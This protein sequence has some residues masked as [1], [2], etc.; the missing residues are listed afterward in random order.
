MKKRIFVFSFIFLIV[1][2][3]LLSGCSTE[4]SV[5]NQK[6][7]ANETTDEQIPEEF[8]GII[9]N[10]LF[11][12]ITAYD[13]RL[14]K[15]EILD[16]NIETRAVTYKV[17]MMDIYGE[18]LAVYTCDTDD[19]YY[20]T[21]LT[22]TEDG[23]FLFVLSFS[24]HYIQSE[25]RWASDKGYTSH[26][27][28]CDSNGNLQFDA[29]FDGIDGSALKYCFEKNGLFYL[30]GDIETSA[31]KQEGVHSPTDI[32]MAI[33]D[34]S[35]KLLDEQSICGSD[36]DSLI[37]AETS[38]DNFLLYV[39]SQSND[40]A[41][42]GSNSGGYNVG[43]LIT[44]DDDLKITQMYIGE[45]RDFLDS[46]IGE[47]DGMAIYTTDTLLDNFDA[48]TPEAFIDYGDFY[49]I[50]S[51]NITGEY[52]NTPD[53]INSIWHYT[54]TVYSAYNYDGTLLFRDSVDSSPDYDSM[55][56]NIME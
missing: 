11:Y 49:L 16:E 15:S 41:F 12:D 50:V 14:L 10:N 29:K 25:D 23:G 3:L 8:K 19:S 17:T 4:S 13:N 7:P 21:T 40:G 2:T 34:N 43:W 9:E 31:T 44:V 26:V 46:V 45:G 47:R 53:F 30:F 5:S 55:V 28:K 20:V 1:T 33:L 54:E 42:E 39:L 27:I 52:E 37:S 38:D 35:G 56:E 6:E 18:E 32:Y 48:G 36:Y 22:A 24:D 51:E